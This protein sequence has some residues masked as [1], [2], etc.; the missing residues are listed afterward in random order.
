MISK[1]IDNSC[2]NCPSV[3][4]GIFCQLAYDELKEVSDHK[5]TNVYKKGQTLFV[6]GNHPFG[7][8]CISTGNIKVTKVGNDG[9]ESIVRIASAGDVLGHRS[10]FTD[11]YYTATATALEDTKVCFLDKKFIMKVIQENPS[12]SMNVIEKLSTDMGAA[13][14]KLSSLHQKNVRERLAELLLL[15]KESH[16][17]E[18]DDGKTLIKLKLTREEMATMIGTANETLIRFMSEFKEEG[19][20]EQV[21]KQIFIT[22]EEKLIDWA[23]VSY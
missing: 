13:E 20:I 18:Q 11:Q 4:K 1:K 2:E 9:K 22:D 17:E 10:L 5:V 12:V 14:N 7:L 15:L 23:N 8:Y 19:L 6:Q 21:G 3:S 16:G